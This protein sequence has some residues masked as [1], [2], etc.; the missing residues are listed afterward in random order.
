MRT[1]VAL[2][3]AL[4][5]ACSNERAPRVDFSHHGT[6]GAPEAK[7][8]GDSISDEELRVRFLEMSPYARARYQTVEQKREYLEGLVRFELLT[9]EAVRRGLANDP[10]VVE[11]TKKVMVQRLLNAELEKAAQAEV[12]GAELQA[13]YD[14]HRTDYVRP[15]MVRLSHIF[16]AAPKG[17]AARR[18][19]QL[20]RAKDAL[21]QAQA[22]NAADF[23][24]FGRLAQQLSEEPRTK[25]LDGDL[26]FLTRD[27]L[28]SQYGPEVL[29]ASDELKAVNDVLPR[30]VETE[31]GLHVLK[32]RGRQPAVN[33]SPADVKLQLEA[34]IRYDRRAARMEQLVEELKKKAGYQV[35]AEALAKVP[36]DLKAPM[37]QPGGPS[38]GFLGPPVSGPPAPTVAPP[39][40]K[41]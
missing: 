31:Q 24:A 25:P 3:A 9:Q 35:D 15:E 13:E 16:F 14:R 2:L 12:T 32:L 34:R 37:Q 18:A 28:A 11:S 36:V 26:R 41:R 17:D 39:N 8:G 38:P 7:I 19:A 23:G 29:A 6:P 22:L 21:K 27:E 30:V 1:T 40:P 33:Q 20:E 10:E 5:C 4:A